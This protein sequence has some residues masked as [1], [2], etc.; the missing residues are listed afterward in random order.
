MGNDNTTDALEQCFADIG[1]R[2]GKISEVSETVL[3]D[4]LDSICRS[5]ERITTEGIMLTMKMQQ[6]L[7][8]YQIALIIC[9]RN[10]RL[11][12]H[13]FKPLRKRN[14]ERAV[15]RWS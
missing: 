4:T 8:P 15:K 2:I 6:P 1:G 5:F 13:G 11:R 3:S 9:V 10:N 14:R 7:S 12:M